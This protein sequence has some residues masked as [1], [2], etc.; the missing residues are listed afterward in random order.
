MSC[1][2]K[3]EWEPKLNL[4]YGIQCH[5]DKITMIMVILRSG[6]S[7]VSFLKPFLKPIFKYHISNESYEHTV[8]DIDVLVMM[9]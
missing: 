5:G 3:V 7:L 8:E 6:I 2:V 9:I 1:E 4:V